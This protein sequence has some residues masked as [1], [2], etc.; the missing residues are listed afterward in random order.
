MFRTATRG[1]FTASA[2]LKLDQQPVSQ[3]SSCPGMPATLSVAA[4]GA[5]PFT[6]QWRRNGVP[7]TASTIPSA[8]TAALTLSCPQ[9]ADSGVYDVLVTAP[10][11]SLLSTAS[12]VNIIHQC[13]PADIGVQGGGV[14]ACGDGRLD[15]NDFVAFIDA[16]FAGLPIADLGQ[17]GGVPGAD[18]AI[19]NNDF[20]VFIDLFFHGC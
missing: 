2:A 12:S 9:A 1:S 3:I 7:L 15:N 18:G 6:Y 20:V 16:F 5:G 4:S 19:D 11:G 17:Q 8:A 13:S 14:S 10:C